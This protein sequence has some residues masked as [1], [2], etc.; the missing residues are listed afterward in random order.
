LLIDSADA[1]GTF[2][3]VNNQ[4][5]QQDEWLWGLALTDAG[6]SEQCLMRFQPDYIWYVAP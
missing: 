6:A 5:L 3:S 4:A 1:D 2:V